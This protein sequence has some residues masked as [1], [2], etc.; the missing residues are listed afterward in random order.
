MDAQLASHPT[1]QTLHAHGQGQLDGASAES[2]KSHLADCP[3]CRRRVAELSAE[4]R[5]G[6]RLDATPEPESV[7]SA[8]SSPDGLSLLRAAAPAPTP[9]Q[10]SSLP[11]GL[12]NHPD[13]QVLRELGRGGM[14]VVYLAQN[15][16]MGRLEVL[17]V[18]GGHVIHRPIVLERFLR[19]IRSAARLSHPN[20]VTAYTALRLDEGLVL[21][22][23]YVEGFDLSKVVK[24]QG[25]LPIAHA[26]N[27]VYQAA[28]GLQHAHEYGMVHRDIKPGNLMLSRQ[29]RAKKALVKVLD[30]GLAKVT[31]EGEADS[32]LT[33]EG[34]TLGTPDY[35]APEQIRNAQAADIRAD[36]YSLGCTLYYLL[37]GRPPFKGDNLW[38]IYQ[39]HFSMDANPLNL[40]RPEVSAELGALVAKMM[41]K[42]PAQRFQT[43]GAVAQA[44]AP[45]FKSAATAPASSSGAAV[46]TVPPV[47]PGQ[48]TAVDGPAASKLGTASPPPIPSGQSPSSTGSASAEW[49]TLVE[50][51]DEI[52]SIPRATSRPGATPR[53]DEPLPEPEKIP[54]PRPPWFWPSVA[55]GV[56]GMVML[57]SALVLVLRRGGEADSSP[58]QA[59]TSFDE[60]EPSPAPTRTLTKKRASP[61]PA[62]AKKSSRPPGPQANDRDSQ[63]AANRTSPIMRGQPFPLPTGRDP[64]PSFANE[65]VTV[66]QEITLFD[67][68]SLDGWTPFRS[69]RPDPNRMNLIPVMVKKELFC[70]SDA[71]GRLQTN[72]SYRNFLLKL[73]Y[74]LPEGGKVS[75]NNCGFVLVPRDGPPA[76]FQVQGSPTARINFRL[77]PG[78][79][80]DLYLIGG[81]QPPLKIP[82]SNGFERPAGQWNEFAL[83]L[84]EQTLKCVLN[85]VVVQNLPALDA[86][87]FH[88]AFW[89]AGTEI[90]YRNIRLMPPEP[91]TVAVADRTE[92]PRPEPT[93][94][95]VAAAAPPTPGATPKPLDPTIPIQEDFRNVA[96]GTLPQGWISQVKNAAVQSNPSVALA[97]KDPGRPDRI[98]FPRM[99]FSGDFIINLEFSLPTPATSVELHLQGASSEN[100][101]V[102]V[103]GNGMVQ[104]QVGAVKHFRPG[105]SF[106][107]GRPN[108]LRLERRGRRY[109]IELNGV[110][111]GEFR[112]NI[113]VVSY[114]T[115]QLALGP[116]TPPVS[117]TRKN[118]G[119][120]NMFVTP[121]TPLTPSRGRASTSPR[122]HSL[123]VEVPPAKP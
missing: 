72:K 49:K 121:R 31:S 19:E 102:S 82:R 77:K 23:E 35:I 100:L 122:I 74:R 8:S 87:P 76:P 2:V 38:D 84:D 13:Y 28:L 52:P 79:S 99:D 64:I 12:A 92:T 9:V 75:N 50:V 10:A 93:E 98:E 110:S 68:T 3:D 47:M 26:C 6:R 53:P 88:I 112:I 105:G 106:D 111:P 22:M 120:G 81:G 83:Q 96:E 63:L 118:A 39:A 32:G 33:R 97:L 61:P 89:A 14:G 51:T 16:L 70:P 21:A 67:G 36:I 59:S 44:L 42:D 66:Q 56:L 119:R 95:K 71:D 90:S 94:P 48:T 29:G 11:P 41:A 117:A 65:I 30:F 116:A 43:P 17:K 40:V 15:T 20:V 57:A 27:Y 4:S 80:G 101:F 123:R 37:S 107:A 62:L 86:P 54:A 18:V 1:D 104:A 5:P 91:A 45:F 55:A 78:E 73:E 34:A 108:K 113:G 24:T 114:K 46:R 25:P 69:N 60:S 103:Y 109:N 7:G 58:T 85:G 115:L